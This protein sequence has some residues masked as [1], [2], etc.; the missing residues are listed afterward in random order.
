MI[1]LTNSVTNVYGIQGDEHSYMIATAVREVSCLLGNWVCNL[2]IFIPFIIN[3]WTTE[4][5]K[6]IILWL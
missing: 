3:V 1:T 2:Y 6:P 4:E 5:L